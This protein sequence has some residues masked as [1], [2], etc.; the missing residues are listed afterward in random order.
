MEHL[1]YAESGQTLI[2]VLLHLVLTTFD[3]GLLLLTFCR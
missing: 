3:E 1:L 2:S